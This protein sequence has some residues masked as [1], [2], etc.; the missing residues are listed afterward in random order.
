MWRSDFSQVQ[1]DKTDQHAQPEPMKEPD[2]DEHGDLDRRRHKYGT[3][4]RRRA[5]NVE[6][7]LPA[8]H[9]GEVSLRQ[10]TDGQTEVEESIDGT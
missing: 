2:G 3:D 8:D 10:G 9:V 7:L 4:Q 1:R 6:R 5:G